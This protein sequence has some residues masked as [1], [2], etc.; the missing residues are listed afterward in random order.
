[1]IVQKCEEEWCKIKTGKFSGWIKT[2]N[3]WG[4]IN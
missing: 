2:D 4:S 3:I 1:M